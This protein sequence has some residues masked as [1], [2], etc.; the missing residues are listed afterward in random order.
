MILREVLSIHS[1][2]SS[3]KR[4][5]D[6]FLWGYYVS[7]IR[8]AVM[9]LWDGFHLWNHLWYNFILLAFH[10]RKAHTYDFFFLGA[11][12]NWSM[13]SFVTSCLKQLHFSQK[14]LMCEVKTDTRA[15]WN[16]IF[17]GK[18]IARLKLYNVIKVSKDWPQMCWNHIVDVN[19]S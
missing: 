18:K 14:K 9:I 6:T 17:V 3:R 10:F 13:L 7:D 1:L 12:L 2:Q 16:L 15:S 19:V 5:F 11:N 4:S 8:L